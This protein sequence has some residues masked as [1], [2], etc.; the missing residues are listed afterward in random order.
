MAYD[1]QPGRGPQRF[2]RG[3]ADRGPRPPFRPGPPG[4]GGD[5]PRPPFRPNDGGDRPR[6]PFRPNDGGARPRAPF[7]PPVETVHSVRL[8]D[9]EREIEVHGSPPFVRQL[10]DELPSL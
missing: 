8:R 2:D 4:D 1:R 6:P 3:P 10:L 5:R 7:R 9:G